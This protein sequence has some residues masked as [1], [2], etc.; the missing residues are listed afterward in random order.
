MGDSKCLLEVLTGDWS[1]L[2]ISA[3]VTL[4]KTNS[5]SSPVNIAIFCLAKKRLSSNHAKIFKGETVDS[6]PFLRI[7]VVYPAEITQPNSLPTNLTSIVSCLEAIHK[8]QALVVVLQNSVVDK[9]G[10]TSGG[11][12]KNC[13][14]V[15]LQSKSIKY[16][17]WKAC[18]KLY[19][20][21]FWEKFSTNYWFNRN[22]HPLGSGNW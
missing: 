6:L 10:R 4:P 9:F 19:C 13:K 8:L 20:R 22:K 5:N 11:W 14:T 1:Q 7:P 2:R 16:E 15:C 3:C 12:W 18:T 17:D 21:C